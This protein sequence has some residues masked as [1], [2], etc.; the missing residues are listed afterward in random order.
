MTKKNKF[1]YLSLGCGVQSGTLAEM[2]A[3]GVLPPID[4]AIFADTG[5][6]PQYVYDYRDYLKDR[7]ATKNVPLVTVQKGD[8]IGDMYAGKRF[9]S[10]PLYT[11]I[12]THTGIMRRQCTR[13][14]KVEPI[15]KYMKQLLVKKGWARLSKNKSVLINK[16]TVIEA[17][18]GL[19]LDEV[20]RMKPNRNSKITSKWPLI[21]QRMSRHDCIQWLT[22]RNLQVPLKSSCVICPYHNNNYWR[23]L[24]D[25]RPNEFAHAIQVDNDLRN[26]T[27]NIKASAKSDLFLHNQAIPLADVDL[28]TPEEQGQSSFLDMC[29]EGYCGV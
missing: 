19:S 7:L 23:F 22:K 26:N 20:S 18:L 17:W 13:E 14:Y 16:T 27:L 21:D 11:R 3:E 10:I 24:R 9:A 28:R 25:E 5:D 6:E 4:V 12:N 1:T 15:E 29:D 2:I 8:L